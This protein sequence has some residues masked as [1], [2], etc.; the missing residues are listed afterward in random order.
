MQFRLAAALRCL[1]RSGP[2]SQTHILPPFLRGGMGMAVQVNALHDRRVLQIAAGWHHS[3]CIVGTDP[4]SSFSLSKTITHARTRARAHK[5]SHTRAHAH[6]YARTH[7]HARAR[8]RGLSDTQAQH[9][10]APSTAHA[11]AFAHFRLAGECRLSLACCAERRRCRCR[12][13]ADSH[14][15]YEVFTWGNGECDL[16]L[17]CPLPHSACT[18]DCTELS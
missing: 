1:R 16:R 6:A 10:H 3:A 4:F 9:T 13:V 18:R 11:R 15:S 8:A 12:S 14:G 2:L 5:H 7:T 17:A